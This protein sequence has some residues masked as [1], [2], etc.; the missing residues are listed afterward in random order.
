M[1]GLTQA[2][3]VSFPSCDF[4]LRLIFPPQLPEGVCYRYLRKG[5]CRQ[6]NLKRNSLFEGSSRH[7][8][9]TPKPQRALV[10]TRENETFEISMTGTHGLPSH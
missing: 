10:Q 1:G 9:H 3:E 4:I 7:V 8:R 2:E 6:S 5:V